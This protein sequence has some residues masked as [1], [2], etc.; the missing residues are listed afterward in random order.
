MQY[1]DQKNSLQFCETTS[2]GL[3][4]RMIVQSLWCMATTRLILPPRVAPTQVVVVPIYK[5]RL[6][7]KHCDGN[8]QPSLQG[9]GSGG[10][11]LK[12]MIERRSL[13]AS[14]SMTGK[15]VAS[16]CALKSVRRTWRSRQLRWRA[17]MSPENPVNPLFRNRPW[18]RLSED[19]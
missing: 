10:L 8:R 19:Y 4:T 14:N 18:H 1:L 15:C 11:R 13:L 12:M 6:G 3:S 5:K 7:K 2:W 16:H 9:V 17:A